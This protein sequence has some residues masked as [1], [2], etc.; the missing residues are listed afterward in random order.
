MSALLM[1]RR[2]VE[3]VPA[4]K[5][6]LLVTMTTCA[7]FSGTVQAASGTDSEISWTFLIIGLFGGLALFL[8]G[9]ER[10]S[11][12]LKKSAGNKMR[13]ILAAPH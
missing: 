9:M 2:Y 6:F 7:L 10:M 3:S 4:G 11:D 13:M 5:L 12:G 1:T 8:Y